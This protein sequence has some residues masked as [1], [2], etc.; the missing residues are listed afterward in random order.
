MSDGEL[1]TIGSFARSCGLTPSALRFYADSGLLEPAAVDAA[2]GYRYYA[3]DQVARATLIRQLRELDLPLPRI[4]EILSIDVVQRADEVIDAH[5]NAL[6]TRAEAA[7]TLAAAAK[8]TLRT[9]TADAANGGHGGGAVAG[10]GGVGGWG[11]DRVE[12]HG[13]RFVAAVEAVSTATA[14]EPTVPALVGI[15]VEAGDGQLVLTATDRYRLATRTLV[16]HHDGAP[17]AVT[18]HGDDLRAI[19]PWL[20]RQPVIGLR[21]ANDYLEV[22]P[23]G[24]PAAGPPTADAGTGGA[25]AGGATGSDGRWCRVLAPPYPDYRAMLGALP[26]PAVRVLVARHQLLA[27][28]ENVASRHVRISIEQHRSTSPHHRA[29]DTIVIGAPDGPAMTLAFELATLHPTISSAIGPDVMLEFSAPDHP[30]LV[31]SADTGDLTA[32]AMPIH[33]PETEPS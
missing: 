33:L 29:P 14:S 13:L 3:P 8:R 9:P 15:Y 17:W 27:A 19:T 26:V 25:G 12:V 20:R 5:V 16:T 30:V 23:A 6:T 2:S 10:R 31:R 18:V 28:L 7:H 4:A 21:P 11:E 1:M 24:G 22:A 32:I